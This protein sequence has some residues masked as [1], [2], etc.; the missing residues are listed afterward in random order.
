MSGDA[1]EAVDAAQRLLSAGDPAGALEALRGY[2][3]Q[4]SQITRAWSVLGAAYFELEQWE[5]A[6]EAARQTIRLDPDSPRQWSNLGTILR[7][8]GRYDE[9]E[10]AQQRA[11]SLDRSYR[12]ADTELAKIEEERPDES[13]DDGWKIRTPDGDFLGPLSGAALVE[14]VAQGDVEPQWNARRGTGRVITVR[15]AIGDEA[16]DEA[17]RARKTALSA[18]PGAEAKE[19]TTGGPS[20]DASPSSSKV[21]VGALTAVIF[22]LGASLIWVLV[23]RD[24]TAGV[25]D[26]PSEEVAAKPSAE[27]EASPHSRSADS[28]AVS[29]SPEHSPPQTRTPAVQRPEGTHQASQPE[30]QPAPQEPRA[31]PQPQQQ[32]PPTSAPPPAVAPQREITTS[33]A[34]VRREALDAIGDLQTA[35]EVGVNYRDY[36]NYVI[37]AKRELRRLQSGVPSGSLWWAEIELAMY[38]YEFAADAWDWKFDGDG[39]RDFVYEGSP[40]FRLAMMKYG[41]DQLQG[42][43]M[44]SEPMEGFPE[45]GIPPTPARWMLWIDGIVQT[46][47]AS[48]SQHI[49]RASST[50]R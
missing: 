16:C 7:K 43:L 37:E 9:A 50:P 32:S 4:L 1:T 15:K 41:R 19:D 26:R 8:Q 35:V 39:V 10:E 31:Q 24:Q 34:A 38:D 5:Q 42:A 12:R 14:L 11:L 40:E 17:V 3:P 6:E 48:A 46:A 47:W 30:Q 33:N 49:Q 20:S 36:N 45:A 44:R 18:R 22:V 23:S 27:P 25:T 28:G 21:L 29:A 13:H 2:M